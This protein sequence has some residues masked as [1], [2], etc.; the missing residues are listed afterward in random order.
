V[1]Y[2]IEP[3]DAAPARA[4]GNTY[5]APVATADG[6]DAPMSDVCGDDL[7]MFAKAL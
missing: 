4:E 7:I 5:E 1:S 6:G 3:L 2:A